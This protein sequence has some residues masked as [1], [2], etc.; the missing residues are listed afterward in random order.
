MSKLAKDQLGSVRDNTNGKVERLKGLGT[1]KGVI[2][3]R[4][5]RNRSI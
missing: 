1:T 2:W 4:N 3:K 5:R